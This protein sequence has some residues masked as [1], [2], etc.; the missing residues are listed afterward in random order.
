MLQ[1]SIGNAYFTVFGHKFLCV[2]VKNHHLVSR[3][4]WRLCPG[5]FQCRASRETELKCLTIFSASSC[6]KRR[7]MSPADASCAGSWWAG[8][9]P[10]AN[11]EAVGDTFIREEFIMRNLI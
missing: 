8:V 6:S 11:A 3:L 4:N 5:Q 1:E 2:A 10:R 9:F 7:A